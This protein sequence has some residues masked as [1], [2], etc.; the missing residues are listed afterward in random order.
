MLSAE[1]EAGIACMILCRVQRSVRSSAKEE[2]APFCW[3][4]VAVDMAQIVGRQ[5]ENWNRI[6]RFYTWRKWMGNI[7]PLGKHEMSSGI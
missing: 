6:G 1:D 5:E 4:Y 3:A 2:M 7:F